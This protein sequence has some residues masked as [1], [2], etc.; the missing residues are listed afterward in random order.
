M[1]V[2]VYDER[3]ACWRQTWVDNQGGYLDFSGGKQG[4]R[5][6]LS[7]VAEIDGQ[8]LHQRMVWYD[9]RRDGLMWNWERSPDEGET[10]ETL[11]VIQYVRAR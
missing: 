10:W 9:I 6:I 4:E 11:W 7:R 1:S 2:S 5:M 3:Q 8:Q